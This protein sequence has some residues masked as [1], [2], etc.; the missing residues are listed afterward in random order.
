M[1]FPKEAS[2]LMSNLQLGSAQRSYALVY[3]TNHPAKKAFDQN[4]ED[5]TNYIFGLMASFLPEIDLRENPEKPILFKKPRTGKLDAEQA[6]KQFPTIISR[7]MSQY[8][9]K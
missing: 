4:E 1:D 8:Y 9:K 6:I 5:L 3:N 7:I 2:E